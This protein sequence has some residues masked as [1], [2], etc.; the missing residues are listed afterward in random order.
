MPRDRNKKGNIAEQDY[1]LSA[2]IADSNT[3]YVYAIARV[4]LCYWIIVTRAWGYFEAWGP[5]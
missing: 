3:E 2:L 1:A 5:Q 4:C